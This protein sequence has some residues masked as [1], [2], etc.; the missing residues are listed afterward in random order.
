MVKNIYVDKNYIEDLIS[1]YHQKIK[2]IDVGSWFGVE[3]AGLYPATLDQIFDIDWKSKTALLEL[4]DPFFPKNG[5]SGD[6]PERIID[7]VSPLIQKFLSKGEKLEILSSTP[8][9]VQ[10]CSKQFPQLFLS[11]CLADEHRKRVTETG[12]HRYMSRC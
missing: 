9:I 7:T 1:I 8:R 6:Y 4:R 2:N 12:S 11:I 3:F 5:D 10:L